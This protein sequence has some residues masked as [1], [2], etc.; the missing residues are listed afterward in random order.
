MQMVGGMGMG[1]GVPPREPA[2]AAAPLS[3]PF[4]EASDEALYSVPHAQQY[5]DQLATL[6]DMGFED[7]DRNLALLHEFGGDVMKVVD[8][9]VS[10][11]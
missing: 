11:Q 9:L 1:T 7:L 2:G 6:V 8:K 4:E 10:E 5:A 3:S